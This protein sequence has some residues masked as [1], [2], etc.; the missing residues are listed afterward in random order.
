MSALPKPRRAAPKPT[1][2]RSTPA[3][4][5]Q[6]SLALWKARR[7]KGL[8]IDQVEQSV[9][10]NRTTIMKVE[11]GDKRLHPDRLRQ[12]AV[13]LCIVY[14]ISPDTILERPR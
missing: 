10:F 9:N 11:K 2:R 12:I 4:P 7:E 8:T 5:G 13:A 1:R 3:T 6:I 14:E